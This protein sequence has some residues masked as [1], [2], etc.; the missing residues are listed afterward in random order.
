MI[1]NSLKDRFQF[2]FKD[3]FIA[4][5]ILGQSLKDRIKKEEEQRNALGISRRGV[6]TGDIVA[7]KLPTNNFDIVIPRKLLDPDNKEQS[8]G[9]I[10]EDGTCILTRN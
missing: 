3:R 5:S 2:R 1:F 4:A 9:A 8:I 10:M 6:I 7:K